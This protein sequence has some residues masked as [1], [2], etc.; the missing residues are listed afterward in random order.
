MADD[1]IGRFL[2]NNGIAGDPQSESSDTVKKTVKGLSDAITQIAAKSQKSLIFNGQTAIYQ[3][4]VDS[5]SDSIAENYPYVLSIVDVSSDENK[6]KKESDKLNLAMQNAAS[7]PELASLFGSNGIS[8]G[9][10]D[11]IVQT[12]TKKYETVVDYTLPINPQELTIQTPFAIKTTVTSGGILEEHNGAPIKMITINGTTGHRI[13]RQVNFGN[14]SSS[15]KNSLTDSI[16]DV[17]GNTIEAAGT[18]VKSTTDFTNALTGKDSV[19]SE[20]VKYTGYYQYHMLKMFLET[21]AEAKKYSEYSGWRLVLRIPK[22]KIDY[23]VTPQ[24]F[25]T[26]KSVASPNEYLYTIQ[27]L[28]WAQLPDDQ[29]TTVS[30][31]NNQTASYYSR[32]V[33]ALKRAR[34]AINSYQNIVGAVKNDIEV[35]VL[36]PINNVILL[37]KDITGIAKTVFD[38]PVDVKNLLK[39]PFKNA[40]LQLNEANLDL[41]A[42]KALYELKIYG[43]SDTGASAQ[44]S[45]NSQSSL[46]KLQDPVQNEALADLVPISNLQV[47]N[48]QQAAIDNATNTAKDYNSND[49]KKLI[50]NLEATYKA[51]EPL[52][53]TK[54]PTEPEWELLYSLKDSIT[55]LHSLIIGVDGSTSANEKETSALDSYLEKSAMAFWQGQAAFSNINFTK[56]QSKIAVP[57]PY[58]ATL[59]QLAATYL[60]TPERWIEIAALNGLQAPYIDEEG[61]SYKLSANG[62]SN[63]IT[64][65][66]AN[67]FYVGQSIYLSSDTELTI[68]RKIQQIIEISANN[69]LITL[70]GAADLVKF[71]IVDNAQIKAYLPYTINSLSQI[72]IPSKTQ[73]APSN[74]SANPITYIEDTLDFVKF[75]KIDLLLDSKGDL[76]ITNNGFLN[77]AFGKTNLF[78]AAKMIMSTPQGSLLLHPEFGGGIEA[79][80]SDADFDAATSLTRIST[81]FAADPRFKAPNPIKLTQESGS[82]SIDL[83]VPVANGDGVLPITLPL[84]S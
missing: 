44:P 50:N 51:I 23:I 82:L 33:T 40:L 66:S 64:T 58:K 84:K 37:G 54:D 79:G 8:L 22:D 16:K 9:S 71:K 25:T 7:N 19:T 83:V 65:N 1:L 68:N 3:S 72:Y 4:I 42:S 73:V 52:I 29:M 47:S 10:S 46:K 70:D 39:D 5:T 80:T 11:N 75:T 31:N 57:F 76:A 34:S 77:L 38:F 78:Q 49:F 81:S 21:Y 18:A 59:E 27:M 36:G 62:S 67:N 17:F 12:A 26:R 56:P 60:G 35:N 6:A 55:S 45:L 24:V 13:N 28:A 20:D 2:R 74:A 53:A 41:A 63:Q 15:N 30:F 32:A 43:V 69:Y 48:N 14:T 61:F